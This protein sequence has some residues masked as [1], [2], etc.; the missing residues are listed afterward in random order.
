V[1]FP[2]YIAKRYLFSKSSN[3]AINIITIIAALGVVVSAMALFIVLSVFSGLKNFSLDFIRISDPDLKISMVKGKSFL[4]TDSINT[5]LKADARIIHFSKVLEEKAFFN[6]KEKQHIA[7]IKG[8]DAT[9]LQ[10]NNIDT[11]IYIGEWIDK[12]LA[13]SVVIGNGISSTLSL[14]T[15]DFIEP[16]KAYVPKPGKGYVNNPNSAFSEVNLQPV[17]IF[18]ITEEL[19]GKYVFSTLETAQHLLNYQPNQISAIELRLMENVKESDVV[20]YLNSKLGD[21]YKVETRTQLNAVFYKMI[22]TENIVSYLI[23]TL[24]LIIA[25]FNVIGAIVM[26]ILDKRENLKTL[27]SIGATLKEIRKIFVFQGFLLTFF[28]MFIGLG[29][30]IIFVLLQKQF[31]LIMI[32]PSLAYPVEYKFTNVLVVASTILF[33]G[34]ISAI[35]ASSRITRKVVE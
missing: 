8:V 9:Y 25:L 1:N 30:A 12:E 28:G 3:N 5:I 34:Y 16:L 20:A 26:M 21:V 23:F 11:A 31:G 22:N 32:T 2:L 10:V 19:D 35:I 7:N 24:I 17:G 18:R 15:Y 14:G 6:Y 33:L 13:N 29:L 4:F 27:F